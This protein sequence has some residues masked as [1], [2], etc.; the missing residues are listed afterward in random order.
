MVWKNKDG[1]TL[2]ELIIVIAIIIVLLGVSAVF[3]ANSLPKGRFNAS[4]R[5]ISATV[6]L[7]RLLS[8][9]EGM[10]QTFT[11]DLDAKRYGI[12]GRGYR[13]LPE[14]INVK[15]IDPFSNEVIN[16]KYQ[17][18]FQVAGGSEGGII[19]LKQGKRIANIQI[20]PIIG[21]AMVK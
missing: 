11:I 18:I 14:Y 17:F 16:G 8:Q 4:V 10:P 15:I 9:T 21:T 3:F 20:D 7:A 1:F 13:E 5:D 19:I 2:L 12:E 6:R